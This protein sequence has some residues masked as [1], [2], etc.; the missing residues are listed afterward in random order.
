VARPFVSSRKNSPSISSPSALSAPAYRTVRDGL[1]VGMER[2]LVM[3]LRRAATSTADCTARVRSQARTCPSPGGVD[4]GALHA[5]P[6]D[7]TRFRSSRR[8]S[9][10]AG[11][12]AGRRGSGAFPSNCGGRDRPVVAHDSYL[13]NIR[14]GRDWLK[15]SVAAFREELNAPSVWESLIS[16]H[17]GAYRAA[18]E[19]DGSPAS[20]RP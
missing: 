14:A 9:T 12:A 17:P 4:K 2:K 7:A 19:G 5:K 8:A 18:S 16:L 15:R 6:S 20:P 11:P 10:V 13:L 1:A 3:A